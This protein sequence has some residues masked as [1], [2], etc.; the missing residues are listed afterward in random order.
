MNQR[1][2]NLSSNSSL[3]CITENEI[4]DIILK[5][6]DLIKTKYLFPKIADKICSLLIE[7]LESQK[8]AL[9]QDPKDLADQLLEDVQSFNGDKHLRVMFDIEQVRLLRKQLDENDDSQY[10][11]EQ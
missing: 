2:R 6:C 7:K 5:I 4:E 11:S 1:E 3:A 9:L 8:Y 10:I